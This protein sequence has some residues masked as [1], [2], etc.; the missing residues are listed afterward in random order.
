MYYRPNTIINITGPSGSGKSSLIRDVFGE[1]ND[2]WQVFRPSDVLREQAGRLG[3]ELTSPGAYA[4]VH[5]CLRIQDPDFM[6][7]SIL[8]LK[9]NVVLDGLRVYA[10]AKRLQGILKDRYF[11]S[12]VRIPDDMRLERMKGRPGRSEGV[13]SSIAE[14]KAWDNAAVPEHFDFNNIRLMA[15]LPSEPFDISGERTENAAR[16]AMHV[17]QI[18][19]IY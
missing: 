8:K 11:T 10:D 19:N 18:S 7:N 15:N 16:Y 17:R 12:I 3:V 4:Q 6:V 1:T 5:D 2:R 14:L 13:P 9:G